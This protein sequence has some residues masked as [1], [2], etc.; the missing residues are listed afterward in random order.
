MQTDVIQITFY[1]LFLVW[2]LLQ[3]P[4]RKLSTES[5]K[6]ILRKKNHDPAFQVSLKY[7]FLISKVNFYEFIFMSEYPF[8]VSV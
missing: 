2:I 3:L 8:S 6:H 5:M 1:I 4:L 7:I